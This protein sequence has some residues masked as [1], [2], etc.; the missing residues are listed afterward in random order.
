MVSYAWALHVGL[1]AVVLGAWA[2]GGLGYGAAARAATLVAVLG[3]GGGGGVGPVGRGRRVAATRS[4]C[5]WRAP[6]TSLLLM[7][8][9]VVLLLPWLETGF[10]V[11][12]VVG[13]LAP[14]AAL[15]WLPDMVRWVRRCR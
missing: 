4:R 2:F 7:A 12:V 1:V 6:C 8:M 10:R 9:P 5:D 13:F 11:V 14:L 15:G 3:L